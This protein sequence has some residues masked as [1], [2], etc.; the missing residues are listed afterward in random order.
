MTDGTTL[1]LLVVTPER[2]VLEDTASSIALPAT[3]GYV[4]ILP[5]HAPLIATLG[6]GVLTA[7]QG[8]RETT[9]AI[10]GGFFEVSDDRVTV[11]ADEAQTR[12]EID[13]LAARRELEEGR[14]ALGTASGA[15]QSKARK[16]IER[17]QAQL[18][19]A[20]GGPTAH[21]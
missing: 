21:A 19:V 17:A 11:L 2:K 16:K 1:H 20:T 14:T 15:D 10:V 9:L 6:I 12:D 8:G 3:E 13:I 5:R 7:R 18:A 4:T